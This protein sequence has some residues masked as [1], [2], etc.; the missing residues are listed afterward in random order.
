M[1]TRVSMLVVS[2]AVGMALAQTTPADKTKAKTKAEDSSA[3][4]ANAP[5]EMKTG[6]YKGVLVDMSCASQSTGGTAAA[7]ATNKP[8]QPSEAANSANRATG[9][10]G[11]TCP[12]T[13]QSNNIGMKLDNGQTVRFDLVGNQRAQDAL[14][15]DKGWSKD[16]SAN[17]PIHA[18]VDGVLQGDKLIVSSI[19]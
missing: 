16:L 13:A 6:S 1:K 19:H 14:K 11:A 4:S 17:K 10:S 9:D 5:A 7:P 12:I 15:N 3:A 8:S 2:L 18:K